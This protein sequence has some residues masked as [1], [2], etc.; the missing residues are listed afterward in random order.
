MARAS[1]CSS[2]MRLGQHSRSETGRHGIVATVILALLLPVFVSLLPQP[3]L[4]ASAALDRDIALSLCNPSGEPQ[5]Q[6]IPHHKPGHDHCILCAVSGP[7]CSP[8]LAAAGPAFANRPLT[9][10][11]PLP[12]QALA[13]SLPLRALLESS[14]PRGPP[15]L[16]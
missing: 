8:G 16:T 9:A 4:S 14:P 6:G 5:K 2:T 10:A 11:V 13:P 12:L 3:A 1:W 15:T 7:S